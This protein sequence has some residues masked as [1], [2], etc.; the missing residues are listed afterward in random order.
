[1]PLQPN[2]GPLTDEWRGILYSIQAVVDKNIAIRNLQMLHDFG[3]GNSKSNSILWA[4][5]QKSPLKNYDDAPK[6][7]IRIVPVECASNSACVAK[8]LV[9]SCCPAPEGWNEYGHYNSSILACCPTVM[10]YL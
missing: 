5:S 6:S 2:N 9:G 1:M 10:S 7:I 8:G 4:Y 3:V